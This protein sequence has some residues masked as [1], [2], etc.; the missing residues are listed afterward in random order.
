MPSSHG[1]E[2]GFWNLIEAIVEQ[3]PDAMIYADGEGVIRIWNR[4]A[5]TLFGFGAVEVLGGSLDRIIPERFLRAHWDGFRQAL[6]TGQTKYTGRTLTTRSV[7]KNGGKLYV[8]LSFSLVRDHAGFVIGALA[9]ARDRT[10]RHMPGG[11]DP[12]MTQ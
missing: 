12:T 11:A 1:S 5:E 8:D 7:H 6:E 10:E 2:S 4:A 9:I 3:A